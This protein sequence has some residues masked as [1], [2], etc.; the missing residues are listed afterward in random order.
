MLSTILVS[1]NAIGSVHQT[2]DIP[3][4][5]KIGKSLL[6]KARRLDGEEDMS[7]MSNY[8]IKFHSCHTIDAYQAERG[9]Q[10]E[11][12]GSPFADQHLV[13][14][15]LCPT[16]S[17]G[18]SNG[19]GDYVVAM[20]DFLLSFREFAEEE[21][22]QECEA[23]MEACE[24]YSCN[25]DDDEACE[26]QCLASKGYDYCIE[27]ENEEEFDAAE[28]IEE[29]REAEFNNDDDA[30]N[31]AYYIGAY[32][33]ADGDAIFLGIFTD[34]TCSVRDYGDVYEDYNYGAT[35][36]YSEE[37]L[38]DHGCHSCKEVDDNDD[39][40]DANNGEDPDIIQL[41]EEA[42]EL[43]AKCETNVAAKNEYTKDERSC[44]YI[45]SIL[46]SLVSVHNGKKPGSLSTAFA[47]VFLISTVA[48]GAYAFTLYSKLNDKTID[49]SKGGAGGIMA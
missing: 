3:A 26:N 22:E 28:Y 18:S 4:E 34:A 27:D 19:C 21:K 7:W 39:A 10:E 8:S 12:Q 41:C 20:A 37:S 46:P 47:W 6:G 25:V 35:L 32:C 23:A 15:Q 16:A 49:L 24:Y 38:V 31:P 11:G 1:V 33:G 36:P 44:T 13:Q 14:F 29:C 42:Y 40:D 45:N 17:C 43:S 30:N 9:G 5:S 2:S 48:I